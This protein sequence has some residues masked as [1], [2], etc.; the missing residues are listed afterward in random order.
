[1]GPTERWRFHSTALDEVRL[2][3]YEYCHSV[4]KLFSRFVE[5]SRLES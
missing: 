2:I 4:L 3:H 1:M 5:R